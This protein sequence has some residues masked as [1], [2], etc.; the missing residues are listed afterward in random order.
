MKCKEE[1]QLLQKEF[2][3]NK[4]PKYIQ[5]IIFNHMCL[6]KSETPDTYLLYNSKYAT[7]KTIYWRYIHLKKWIES[8]GGVFIKANNS[9]DGYKWDKEYC[10]LRDKF[11]EVRFYFPSFHS[12]KTIFSY[13][14]YYKS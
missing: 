11:Y 13:L 7:S 14:G 10:G 4:I 2:T 1:L 3:N 8:H 12:Y 5:D 6:S 9:G